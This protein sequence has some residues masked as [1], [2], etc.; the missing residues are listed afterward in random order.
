[1]QVVSLLAM[2]GRC[3]RA[4]IDEVY[5][6]LTGAAEQMLAATPP[7][8]LEEIDEEALKSHVLGLPNV[9]RKSPCGSFA[10]IF[11]IVGS[12]YNTGAGTKDYQI[13][14]RYGSL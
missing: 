8:M 10:I 5:L 2:K 3:E 1:M 7:D 11:F 4:S 12:L 13:G 6:D 9:C 14:L